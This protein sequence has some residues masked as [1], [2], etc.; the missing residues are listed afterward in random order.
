M[1]H[2]SY[3]ILFCFLIIF[4]NDNIVAKAESYIVY[5]SDKADIAKFYKYKL[6]IFDSDKHPALRPLSD[7][8]KVILA[9]LSLVD[10][11]KN[12]DYFDN[13]KN[14]GL[15]IGQYNNIKDKYIIDYK[16]EKWTK[17]IIE[18][19][20]PKI[21]RKGFDGILIDNIDYAINKNKD[22]Q[23]AYKDN[24]E[25]IINIIKAIRLQYPEIKIMV[26]SSSSSIYKIVADIDM[27]MAESIYSS[28]TEKKLLIN[29]DYKEKVQLLENLKTINPK[30]KLYSLDFWNKNDAINIKNIY[31]TQR[32]NGFIPYVSV[33]GLNEI[34]EE[35]L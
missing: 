6:L 17:I 14:D 2:F 23:E 24:F 3:I 20:V 30:L 7:R 5:Y 1:K 28:P 18:E 13:I 21:L 19:I 22:N 8:N 12:H 11:N 34:L 35:P 15:I 33:K 31:Q 25:Y 9:K 26:N 10:I 29:D 4:A 27:V 16:N 32:Q